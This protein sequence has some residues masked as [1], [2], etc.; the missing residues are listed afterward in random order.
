MIQTALIKQKHAA[1]LQVDYLQ[2]LYTYK[3]FKSTNYKA[4][5]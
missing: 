1:I 2:R 4:K 3:Y 5:S